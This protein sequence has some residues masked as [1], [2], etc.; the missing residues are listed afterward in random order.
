LPDHL[1]PKPFVQQSSK[2]STLSFQLAAAEEMLTSS[3]LSELYHLLSSFC[4]DVKLFSKQNVLN[5][6]LGQR[7][8]LDLN[9]C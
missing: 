3:R 1:G 9:D 5:A 8:S 2:D 4:K 7:A 6:S